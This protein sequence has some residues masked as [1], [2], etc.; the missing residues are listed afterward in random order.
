[1]KLLFWKRELD[2]SLGLCSPKQ[3]CSSPCCC[4]SLSQPK[5]PG[6]WVSGCQLP[7][8]ME[9]TRLP[10]FTPH[11][12]P[13]SFD[14]HKNVASPLSAIFSSPDV[15]MPGAWHANWK[16][17]GSCRWSPWNAEHA[18]ATLWHPACILRG[19]R[20]PEMLRQEPLWVVESQICNLEQ[21]NNIDFRL[22][23]FLNYCFLW[24]NV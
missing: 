5:S 3:L 6:S 18:Y 7:S 22:T 21:K 2:D 9:H 13:L 8:S 19:H 17:R 23:D 15:Y 24:Y 12:F 1:M 10:G 20:L 11:G 16:S 4:A 14:P